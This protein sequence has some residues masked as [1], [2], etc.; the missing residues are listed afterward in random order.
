MSERA[1]KKRNES[2]VTGSETI[3][4]SCP[5]AMLIDEETWGCKLLGPFTVCVMK[6]GKHATEMP[7]MQDYENCP[8]AKKMQLL[9]ELKKKERKEEK[10]EP[11]TVEELAKELARAELEEI[12]EARM[13][14]IMLRSLKSEFEKRIEAEE[15]KA[16][17]LEEIIGKIKTWLMR[18]FEGLPVTV[19]EISREEKKDRVIVTLEIDL[20]K[21][22]PRE[23]FQRFL[24]IA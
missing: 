20:E 23:E 8:I 14:R 6:R 7:T 24:A 15:F 5:Y 17:C 16:E 13:R 3:S 22:L 19:T 1:L 11:K 2:S 9:E 21:R 18:K 10:K 12:A 4:A